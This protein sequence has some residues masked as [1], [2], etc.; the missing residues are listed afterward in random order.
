M[1]P[2]VHRE[3][4]Y[5]KGKGGI[6]AVGPGNGIPCCSEAPSGFCA[7]KAI[8][9]MS[10]GATKGTFGLV[11]GGKLDDVGDQ[12]MARS[13]QEENKTKNQVLPAIIM[14]SDTYENSILQILSG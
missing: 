12:E 10:F 5:E 9:R 1:D 2:I 7:A 4:C 14:A 8:L 11:C 6:D 3:A 13:E